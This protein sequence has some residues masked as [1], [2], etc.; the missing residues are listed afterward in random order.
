MSR[1]QRSES[2][3]T[4]ALQ[5]P[6]SGLPENGAEKS[7]KPDLRGPLRSVAVPDQRCTTRVTLALHRVRDTHRQNRMREVDVARKQISL[8][9]NSGI[10]RRT[11]VRAGL[12]AI[13][14]PAV[15]RVIPA[16]A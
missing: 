8:R 3:A 12:G 16:N 1:A 6:I 5:T 7:G 4:A 11:L 13:A 15:L 2:G 14:A 10:S 9:L